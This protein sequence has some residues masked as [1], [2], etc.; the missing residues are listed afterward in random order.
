MP[1]RGAGSSDEDFCGSLMVNSV[2]MNGHF[3][4]HWDEVLGRMQSDNGA[5]Y[6]ITSWN[7]IP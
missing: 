6:L 1:Q 7:E 2:G 5:R 4:F 3:H